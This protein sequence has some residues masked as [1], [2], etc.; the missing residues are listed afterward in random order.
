MNATT[1]LHGGCAALYAALTVLIF[2]QARLSRTGTL[3]AGACIV[4]AG[5]AAAAAMASHAP[6]GL[7]AGILDLLRPAAWCVFILHLY[8]R[9]VK[10]GRQRGQAFMMM[11]MVAVLV[12][13][14]MLLL[15]RVSPG[16]AVSLWSIWV[17]GR[18][19]FAVCNVLLIENLYLNTPEDARWH[20]NL[21][22]VALGA[23]SVYDIALS[24]DTL[25]FRQISP[26]LYD[27]RALATAIV[28]PLL[29][30]AAARNKP[31]WDVN[32]HVSRTAVFHSATLV[33]SG[34]FL[35][36]LV[37][38][39]EAFRY[40]GADWGGVAEVSLIF[41]GIVT[42]AVLLTSRSA[43]SHL[44]ILLVD[45][46]FSHRYDYRRE[47][48]RCIATLS[49][50]DAYVALHTRVIR[51]LAEIADSPGGVLFLRERDEAAFQWVGSWNMPAAVAPVMDDHPLIAAFRDG[52]WIVETAPVVP[53]LSGAWLAVP[54]NHGGHL[55][56]FVLVAP[57]RAA[58]KLD[59]EVFDL[60]RIVG[61]QVATYV[62]EQRATEVLLQTRQLH[63]YGKRFAFVAHDIKNVSS[64]LSL[65]L[66]NAE[67]HLE[68]PEFQRDMLATIRASVQKIGALIKR[69]QAPESQISQAVIMPGQRLEAIV[70][71]CRR[72]R[73]AAVELEQDGRTAGVAMAPPA[74]DAVVTHLLDNAIE[75]MREA[76]AGEPVRIALR[77]EARRALIDI[78]DNGPGM[79]PEFI[80]DELFRPFRTSKPDGSGI[81][82]FQARELLREAGGDLLVT[83]RPGG[84]TTMRLLLPLVEAPAPQAAT[85]T[86]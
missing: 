39:G 13:S 9:A 76:Q 51:A 27:G 8:R 6:F 68:N 86:A 32:I 42:I 83:S 60:L 74:F 65:L 30:I 46:F 4:T 33:V 20:I 82:A 56:G 80:R 66:S 35:L 11:G 26:A 84:G 36:G 12:A 1:L 19:G 78:A 73:G 17:V 58:F 64:Q 10:S 41:A 48:M 59:R 75:A 62:A 50:P 37:A 70:A 3:L 77:H 52:D 63:E 49:A 61:R 44:R 81:G 85:A 7:I 23:L 18:L 28:A 45:H 38:A 43:R 2:T 53:D 47:W 54:L 25:L 24:G 79:T 40:I 16:G 72:L 57:P 31:D 71:N 22:C 29:A 55:T 14:V 67:T 5:W 21:P 15:G 69:L 34:I